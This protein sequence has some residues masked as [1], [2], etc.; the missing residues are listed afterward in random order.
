MGLGLLLLISVATT[1][2]GSEHT[3][4]TAVVVLVDLSQSFAPLTPE[5]KGA[6]HRI[7]DALHRLAHRT[8]TQ[9]VMIFWSPI[10]SF[11]PGATSP[12]GP[13]ILYRP[14]M[15]PRRHSEEI[16]DSERLRAWLRECVER[17][18]GGAAR[19]EQHTDIAGGVQ[20][21]AE[22]M[23]AVTSKKVIIV[24]SDFVESLPVGRPTVDLRLS[25]ET[26]AMIYKPEIAD[27]GDP[28]QMLR[29]LGE[30]AARF[31]KSGAGSVCRI[32]IK[33]L[34]APSVEACIR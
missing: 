7:G 11:S 21:A 6:L 28:N 16:S 32:A 31:K 22:V 15:V 34:V 19:I 30:W 27:H 24:V 9:P 12:C 18:T 3:L 10:G 13:A 29:R 5:D 33:G 2:T 1:A 25:G 14:R 4:P 26:V 20:H 23:Q 17:F 8:W